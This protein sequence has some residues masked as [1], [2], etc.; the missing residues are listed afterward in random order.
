VTTHRVE[1]IT[2]DAQPQLGQ[3]DVSK[4][5]PSWIKKLCEKFEESKGATLSHPGV[6]ALC[7][8]LIAARVRAE[9]LVAERDAALAELAMIR[10]GNF[11]HVTEADVEAVEDEIGMCRGAWDMVNHRELLAACARVLAGK[12]QADNGGNK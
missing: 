2:L 5:L 6:N 4:C 7:H 9:R 10:S 8:T 11:E 1:Q 12:Q 3:D